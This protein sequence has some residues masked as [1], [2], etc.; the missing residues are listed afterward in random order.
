MSAYGEL[1]DGWRLTCL[2]EL[3]GPAGLFTDGDW[4]LSE[5]LRAG[6]QEVRLLQLG[7]LGVGDFLDKSSKWISEARARELKCTFLRPGDVLISRMAEPIARACVVPGF[8]YPTITA[9]DIAIFRPD[10]SEVRPEWLVAVFN[11]PQLRALAEAESSGTTRKRITRKKLGRL[12]IPLPPLNE[13]DEIVK[14]T[15]AQHRA[16]EHATAHFDA[17]RAGLLHYR[18][19]LVRDALDGDWLVVELHEALHSL[20]N[21]IF[22]SRPAAS[23]PGIPIYRISAVRPMALNVDDVRFAPEDLEGHEKYLV[24]PGDL[25]FTRYSGNPEYV[26]AC[27]RVPVGA[28]PTLHPDKLIRAVVNR[29]VADPAYLEIACSAGV[30]WDDIRARRKTTAGQVG[31][32]GKELAKVRVPLPP[33]AKQAAIIEMAARHLDAVNAL[34]GTIDESFGKA[35]LLRSSLWSSA[36]RGV[37]ARNTRRAVLVGS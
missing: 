17:A 4:I 29:E 16:V 34:R 23:G 33:L 15:A 26:G 14:R 1:L 22:V 6:V 9:V 28:S 37:P 7:D 13:Q 8:D 12:P 36:V 3:V 25:L 35:E 10:P 32:A 27:A 24:E 2:D 18:D 30:T 5:D 21:G 11:S 20:R 19:A 31:I